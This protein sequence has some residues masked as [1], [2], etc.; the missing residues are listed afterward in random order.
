MYRPL[1]FSFT[2]LVND[3]S[4]YEEIFGEPEEN[5]PLINLPGVIEEANPAQELGE[6]IIDEGNMADNLV[7]SGKF[8]ILLKGQSR[9]LLTIF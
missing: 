1:L 6:L 4:P 8:V 2:V 5:L 7:K 3:T 9:Y